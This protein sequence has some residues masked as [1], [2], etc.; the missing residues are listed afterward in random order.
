MKILKIWREIRKLNVCIDSFN[1]KLKRNIPDLIF[2]TFFREIDF[3]LL[4][5][6]TYKTKTITFFKDVDTWS[7]FNLTKELEEARKFLKLKDQE[8]LQLR[9]Q[10]VAVPKSGTP[11]QSPTSEKLFKSPLQ[12]AE[13]SKNSSISFEGNKV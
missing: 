3:L 9:A 5:S 8:I 11:P 1:V 6:L 4:Q 2:S 13:R 12:I 7:K 10:V